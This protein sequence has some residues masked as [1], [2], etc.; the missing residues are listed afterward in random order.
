[1]FFDT[2]TS[3]SASRHGDRVQLFISHLPRRLPTH[4]FREPTFRPSGATKHWK[5][6][7]VLRLVYLFAQLDRLS[8]AFLFSDFFPS[9]SF[10][11]LPL[12]ISAASSVHIVGSLT[13]KLPSMN[14]YVYIISICL[15]ICLSTCLSIYLSIYLSVCLSVW[16][17]VCSL[18]VIL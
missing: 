2:L 6:H 3:K 11:S 17:S 14:I 16:L 5:K 7:C 13:S 12:P 10:S 8:S 4:R 18:S 15:S 9:V 1:M